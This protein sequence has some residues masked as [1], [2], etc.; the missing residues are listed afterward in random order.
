MPVTKEQ[1]TKAKPVG[2]EGPALGTALLKSYPLIDFS[3]EF[4]TP[5]GWDAQVRQSNQF[6]VDAQNAGPGP[7]VTDEAGLPSNW[8][9]KTS[10]ATNRLG[11]HNERLPSQALGWL[12]DGTPDF[13]GGPGGALKK[14][15]YNLYEKPRGALTAADIGIQGQTAESLRQALAPIIEQNEKDPSIANSLKGYGITLSHAFQ[16]LKDVWSVAEDNETIFGKITQFIGAGVG[17]IL[18]TIQESAI[19][20]RN[21]VLG[22]RLLAADELIRT[23]DPEYAAF[24]DGFRKWGGLSAMAPIAVA[25][26]MQLQGLISRKEYEEAVDRNRDAARMAYTAWFDPAAKEEFFRRMQSGTEDPRLL[27]LELQNPGAEMAGQIIYDPL[28]IL[29]IFQ[30]GSRLRAFS[31]VRKAENELT[32]IR[33]EPLANALNDAQNATGEAETIAS[34]RRVLETHGQMIDAVRQR[35]ISLAGRRGLGLT[36]GGKRATIGQRVNNFMTTIIGAAGRDT[37]LSNDIFKGLVLSADS[38]PARHA[39]GLS[40]LSR[41]VRESRGSIPSNVLFSNSGNE[42]AI[43]LRNLLLD[44]EGRFNPSALTNLMEE[45]GGDAEKLASTMDAKLNDALK[46]QFPDIQQQVAAYDKYTELAETDEAAAVNF[47]ERNPLANKQPSQFWRSLSEFDATAQKYFY[48]PAGELQSRLF[49]GAFPA[50]YAYRMMNRWGNFVPTIVDVG[51][52]AAIRGF[53]SVSPKNSIERIAN[54][55]GGVIPEGSIRGL[56]PGASFRDA[57]EA[58]KSVVDR[59]LTQGLRAAAKD[60]AGQAA[61]VV[62][63]SVS[64]TMGS[65]LKAERRIINQELTKLPVEQRQ[66]IA[67]AMRQNWGSVDETIAAL[68]SEDGYDVARNLGFLTDE[69]VNRLQDL[70]LYDASLAAARENDSLDDILRRLDEIKDQ[71]RE[72]GREA[73][74]EPVIHAMDDAWGQ[75]VAQEAH[76]IEEHENLQAA[77]TFQRRV[78]EN[79]VTND[80]FNQA[81][82]SDTGLKRMAQEQI[83]RA[84]MAEGRALGM[85]DD[86]VIQLAHAQLDGLVGPIETEIR[87]AAVRVFEDADAFRDE[88]WRLTEESRGKRLGDPWITRKWNERD[89]G[90]LPTGGPTAKQFRDALWKK[91]NYRDIQTQRWTEYREANVVRYRTVAGRLA[92][93]AGLDDINTPAVRTAELQ[94]IRSRM[95]DRAELAA[96]G[97]MVFR[98]TA[99]D[100]EE[101]ISRIWA[102]A[103]TAA[104]GVERTADQLLT[105]IRQWRERGVT[106]E[107]VLATGLDTELNAALEAIVGTSPEAKR[108]ALEVILSRGTSGIAAGEPLPLG[109]IIRTRPL[110]PQGELGG[111]LA[112]FRLP[113]GTRLR[114]DK[115]PE[116]GRRFQAV[117]FVPIDDAG[118][119][120]R[121][122][123]LDGAPI[124]RVTV[125]VTPEKWS[126]WASRAEGV[127]SGESATFPIP[128]VGTADDAVPSPNRVFHETSQIADETIEALKRDISENWGRTERGA[129]DP[130][131]EVLL[132]DYATG[133]RQRMTEA[134]AVSINVANQTRDFILH[135]YGKRYGIDLVAGYIWPYQFW[136]SRTYMKWMGRLVEHPGLLAAYAKYR[137]ALEQEHAG[138]PDW[139]KYQI[140]TN[141]LLGL[142]SDHPLWFNLERTLNPLNG[143]TDVNFNDPRRRLD[144]WS[145]TV[146]D[147]NKFGPSMWLPFQVAL[148]LKYHM[149][150][151]DDAAGRWAT[152][153]WSPT[154][155]IRDVTAMLDPKGLGVELDPFVNFF[156]GGVEPYER[157]RVARQLAAMQEEGIYGPADIIDAGYQQTGPIWDEA[158]ARAINLRAPDLPTVL[159]PF[160]LGSGFKART[161]SDIRIDEFHSVMYGLIRNKPNLSPEEYRRAWAQLEQQYPFMDALLLSRKSG[162]DRDEALV[163]SVLDRISPAM[164]GDLAELV[165]LNPDL[166]EAFHA[167]KGNL[168]EMTPADRMQ[169]LGDILQLAAILDVPDGATKA[170]WSAAS[171]LYRQMRTVGEQQFGG[172]IWDRVDT[173]FA[174]YDPEDRSA[175]EAYLVAHPIVSEALDW[176][177]YM[178]MSTPLLGA[179]YTSAERIRKFYTRQMHE[180]AEQLY[181]QDLFDHFDVW[182]RLRDAGESRA[183]KKYWDDHPQLKAYMEFRDAQLP[184]IEERVGQIDRLLPES[185]PPQFRGD[186]P[187][188][189][190]DP[191]QAL[192]YSAWAD[193]QYLVYATGEREV[194]EPLGAEVQRAAA[195]LSPPLYR[196]YQDYLSGE[197][198]PPHILQM[199]LDAGIPVNQGQNTP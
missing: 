42:T 115:L 108:A 126:D 140:N 62:E 146:D 31:R 168:E 187:E 111:V 74:T 163:W 45:A 3:P 73:G 97:N 16:Y 64:R 11:P 122:T 2:A 8:Y 167:S 155:L 103:P 70:R 26:R 23:R 28:N 33:Y 176:Q 198:L 159:A 79:R 106:A 53:F 30:V 150:G 139:W 83:F 87:D 156:S 55:L 175:G 59:F 197:D 190:S 130:E 94:L 44:N 153:L 144:M 171:G 72:V 134:R 17:L 46:S 22:P 157:G 142:E 180:T 88:T 20:I 141:E 92:G 125:D 19:F 68:R 34:N 109:T 29:D 158:R 169:F 195:N 128:M 51:P 179:Y 40:I 67:A 10:N 78:H 18:D 89:L 147:L 9:Y 135:N 165:G 104:T 90:D 63:K 100:L 105:T 75:T 6:I 152:R 177:Q 154:R 82:L 15:W 118:N 164:S 124:D 162:P 49:M 107:D 57:K 1:I 173:Y 52:Q 120:V 174:L 54:M 85:S 93:A 178:I 186:I 189:F 65:A 132:R 119:P 38:D 137:T 84:A 32:V 151:E 43:L 86:E 191:N 14:A 133:A 143:L 48:R 24:L 98:A 194:R 5:D 25:T 192:P 199:L 66:I 36:A 81:V 161:E 170:E 112:E 21:D 102:A 47:L 129:L 76:A 110:G 39:E 114:L 101:S 172:D 7:S 138:L 123:A 136:H 56:G 185:I 117:T 131:T 12:P 113:P 61:F 116:P 60:E 149:Q 182:D 193:Q 181:G 148:A 37:D 160:F 96:D 184:L 95:M 196:L 183:A 58:K 99:V 50:S 77:D 27:A 69:E 127:P 80:L 121:A 166:L 188:D 71:Y 41:A 4:N 145:A 35:D 13:G 91:E